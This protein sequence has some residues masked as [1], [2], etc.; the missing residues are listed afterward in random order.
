[1]NLGTKKRRVREGAKSPH[2]RKIKHSVQSQ[3]Q[4]PTKSKGRSQKRHTNT[5]SYIH[6]KMVA[7]EQNIRGIKN[8][9]EDRGT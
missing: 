8:R 2:T 6:R 5:H 3:L 7:G 9:D 1:M 4:L